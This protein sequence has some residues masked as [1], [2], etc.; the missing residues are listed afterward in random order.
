MFEGG[1]NNNNN[2]LLPESQPALK[3]WVFNVLSSN[4]KINNEQITEIIIPKATTFEKEKDV[5]LHLYEDGKALIDNQLEDCCLDGERAFCHFLL[6][7]FQWFQVFSNPTFK[8]I[9]SL[10]EKSDSE[11]CKNG[12]IDIELENNGEQSRFFTFFIKSGANFYIGYKREDHGLNIEIEKKEE[13]I[14]TKQQI[15]CNNEQFMPYGGFVDEEIPKSSESVVNKKTPRLSN[16]NNSIQ[17]E[18]EDQNINDDL[19][20]IGLESKRD[21]KETKLNNTHIFKLDLTEIKKKYENEKLLVKEVEKIKKEN[22]SQEKSSNQIHSVKEK[23]EK[24]NNP[25]QLLV[26]EKKEENLINLEEENDTKKTNGCSCCGLDKLCSCFSHCCGG[27]I[28]I[29]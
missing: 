7:N 12:I 5:C 3:F 21:F 1:N 16:Y 20:S 29:Y 9:F 6:S 27:G 8:I 23:K 26:E 19:N 17:E 24:E 4:L 14:N 15:L 25:I 13:N 28:C 11:N 10:A 22:N 2:N 18:E